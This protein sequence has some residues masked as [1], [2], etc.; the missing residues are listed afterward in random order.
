[1]L[2]THQQQTQIASYLSIKGSKLI[3]H[4][5]ISLQRGLNVPPSWGNLPL[6]WPFS[7]SSKDITIA[8]YR[9]FGNPTNVISYHYNYNMKHVT[10]NINFTLLPLC[11]LPCSE[12]PVFYCLK[13]IFNSSENVRYMYYRNL[14][15]LLRSCSS[16]HRPSKVFFSQQGSM[17]W[18][19]SPTLWFFEP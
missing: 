8:I 12:Y 2:V 17:T 19:L 18:V 5:E 15:E 14:L 1:M 3:C 9:C 6:P 16:I 10:C 7:I 13:N 11:L 4:H